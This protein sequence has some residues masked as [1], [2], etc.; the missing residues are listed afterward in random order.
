MQTG[1]LR[2]E[3][4]VEGENRVLRLDGPLTLTNIFQFQSL[5]RADRSR[6]LIVDLTNV[7]YVDS[8]GIGSLVGAQVSRQN[9]R[10]LTLVGISPRVREALRVTRV[11]QFFRMASSVDEALR[12]DRSQAA[13]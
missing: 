11:E 6:S 5:V 9:D 3:E 13:S 1:P 12:P 7:P 10:T 4:T 8:A 2:I